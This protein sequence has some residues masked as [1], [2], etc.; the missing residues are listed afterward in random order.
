MSEIITAM[1][2]A[3][4]KGTRLRPLTDTTPKPLVNIAG[5]PALMRTLDHLLEAGIQR[6]VIN[7]HYL[8]PMVEDAVRTY[9]AKR[10]RD[11]QPNF[12]EYHFSREETLLETG[13][14]IKK[15]LPLLGDEPFLVVN[16]DAVWREDP[17][18]GGKP[19]LKPLMAAFNPAM[20]DALLT[21]IPVGR[22]D[23]R[24]V[25]HG[26]F[27]LNPVTGVLTRPDDVSLRNVVYSGVHITKPA[28]P[29][30]VEEEAFSL[31]IPWDA[32]IAK[33]RLH[34][35]VYNARWIEMNTMEGLEGLRAMFASPSLGG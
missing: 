30:S 14:G 13:G 31:N 1:V 27:A 16:S 29:M 2:L 25:S 24:T 3:A 23:T 15:A 5:K 7:T 12:R 28:L 33:G 11:G 32:A 21:V 18:Q 8:A 22:V 26:D 9:V 19:L 20:H 34:G 17:M 4:G 35:W 6:V 10:S